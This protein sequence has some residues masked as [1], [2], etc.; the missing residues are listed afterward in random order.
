MYAT[1]LSLTGIASPWTNTL[2]APSHHYSN[3]LV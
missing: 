3:S 2:A 1:R